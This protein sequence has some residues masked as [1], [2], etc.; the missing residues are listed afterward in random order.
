MDADPIMMMVRK[1][2]FASPETVT[3]NRKKDPGK[4]KNGIFRC[5]TSTFC[6]SLFFSLYVLGDVQTRAHMSRFGVVLEETV[7][8][9]DIRVYVRGLVHLYLLPLRRVEDSTDQDDS[10]EEGNT[11]VQGYLFDRLLHAV[12]I[13]KS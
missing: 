4:W 8:P 13:C 7:P 10:L 9:G 5:D 2:A 11:A 12:H 1:R 3:A 6:C